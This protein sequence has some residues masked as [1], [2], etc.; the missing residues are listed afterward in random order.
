[1]WIDF[2]KGKSYIE[3][4]PY[5]LTILG[6]GIITFLI[7]V[8]FHFPSQVLGTFKLLSSIFFLIGVGLLCINLVGFFISMRDPEIQSKE[9]HPYGIPKCV[10]YNPNDLSN[11]DRWVDESSSEY[12]YRLVDLVFINT[13]HFFDLSQPSKYNQRVPVFENYILFF[14][15][16]LPSVPDNYEFCDPNKALERGVGLCSQFSKVI[17]GILDQ[18]GI[19]AD[20]HV[21]SGHVVT[22]AL[23]DKNTH[24]KWV[25]DADLGV[26]F[27]YDI[28]TLENHPDIVAAIYRKY[29]YSDQV[30][31]KIAEVFG[32]QG[33]YIQENVRYC[34]NE[35][36][37]YVYKWVLP[38]LMIVPF[39]MFKLIRFLAN[40]VY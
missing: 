31:D 6:L 29:G 26:V 23:I 19:P 25:L 16:F 40:P 38:L 5:Q 28:E 35:R 30:S 8:Y 9:F 33:N 37:F 36:Q 18:N 22:E 27:E 17:F 4:G 12:A 24:R 7:G 3:F 13:L 20:I 2:L 14:R 1:V 32:K 21:L 11:L 34:Q 10:K 15:S 39:G